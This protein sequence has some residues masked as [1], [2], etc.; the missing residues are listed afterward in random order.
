MILNFSTQGTF[1]PGWG[2]FLEPEGGTKNIFGIIGSLFTSTFIDIFGLCSYALP[3]SLLIFIFKRQI[4][5]WEELI[6]HVTILFTLSIVSAILLNQFVDYKFFGFIGNSAL[7]IFSNYNRKIFVLA[8]LSVNMF[9]MVRTL[10]F[11]QSLIKNTGD[12]TVVIGALL[13]KYICLKPLVVLKKTLADKF[14]KA[15]L[16]VPKFIVN[17]KLKRK[18]K[19]TSEKELKGIIEQ[20]DEIENAIFAKENTLKQENAEI[21]ANQ[22]TE[23]KS[24][25]KNKIKPESNEKKIEVKEKNLTGISKNKHIQKIKNNSEL[26][27]SEEKSSKQYETSQNTFQTTSVQQIGDA[28]PNRNHQVEATDPDTNK[29]SAFSPITKKHRHSK[30]KSKY[31][32]SVLRK[33]AND[34]SAQSKDSEKI[35]GDDSLMDDIIKKEK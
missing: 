20:L 30:N 13:I 16:W 14:P 27:V 8:I 23:V 33:I 19:A 26:R 35:I 22:E 7:D 11:N 32:K 17:Y 34:G 1:D 2:N 21:I 6:F 18:E 28:V 9:F 3:F 10:S 12:G 15:G 31:I 4:A 29:D 25:V 24:Q 5:V